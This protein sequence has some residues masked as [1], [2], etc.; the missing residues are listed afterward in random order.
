MREPLVCRS[1]SA[2]FLVI[3]KLL[4]SEITLNLKAAAIWIRSGTFRELAT[5]PRLVYETSK[6]QVWGTLPFIGPQTCSR[7]LY[8]V[9]SIAIDG[10]PTCN[11]VFVIVTIGVQLDYLHSSIILEWISVLITL[12]LALELFLHLVV[13]GNSF[14][15]QLSGV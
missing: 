15:N 3:L 8:K 6:E 11:V 4:R 13:I 10:P 14:W 9:E 5:Q 7:E 1:L 2:S 12:T